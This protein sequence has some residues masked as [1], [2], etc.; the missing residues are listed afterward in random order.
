MQQQPFR[1]KEYLNGWR[2]V[3]H[4]THYAHYTS[5]TLNEEID[6][7]PLRMKSLT[8]LNLGWY[9]AM[10]IDL[11]LDIFLSLPLLINI[12]D[13]LCGWTTDQLARLTQPTHRVCALQSFDFSGTEQLTVKHI[14]YLA[15]MPSLN[16]LKFGV[17][18]VE[19][20]AQLS[21]PS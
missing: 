21:D 5:D 13:G 16:K 18:S 17:M 19:M 7:T 15:A 20:F 8:H 12:G 10:P 1:P 9:R 6:H 3:R 14:R 2:H 4:Y 11:F